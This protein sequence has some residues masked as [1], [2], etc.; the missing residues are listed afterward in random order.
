MQ[1]QN[2]KN[3]ITIKCEIQFTVFKKK[4]ELLS[5]LI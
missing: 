2:I 1:Y 3:S 5:K 4:N